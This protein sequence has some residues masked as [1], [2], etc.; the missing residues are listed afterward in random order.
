MSARLLDVGEVLEHTYTQGGSTLAEIN[1]T[2]PLL[3]VFL[4]ELR[5]PACQG[6]LGYLKTV[7]RRLEAEGARIVLV[8]EETDAEAD[9]LLRPF[10]MHHL[11]RVRDA[12]RWL[13]RVFYLRK[14]GPLELVSSRVW[15][16]GLPA[17][18]RCDMVPWVGEQL[19]MPGIFVVYQGEIVHE[20][21]HPELGSGQH[22]LWAAARSLSSPS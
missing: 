7:R 12:G 21:S 22:I 4:H 13:C 1:R 14:G 19:Q 3:L 9:A 11:L 6:M 2:A 5:S 8:H 15:K 20:Y 16:E 18:A 10:E 17:L